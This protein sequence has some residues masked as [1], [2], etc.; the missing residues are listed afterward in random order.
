MSGPPFVS[1]LSKEGSSFS[2][3]VGFRPLKVVQGTPVLRSRLSAETDPATLAAQS[4]L[5]MSTIGARLPPRCNQFVNTGL[6]VRASRSE[7][8]RYNVRSGEGAEGLGEFRARGRSD[9]PSS[10]YTFAMAG[11]VDARNAI[12][13][14]AIGT[15][16]A[17]DHYEAEE[18]EPVPIVS[19]SGRDF[20]KLVERGSRR[21]ASSAE[22]ASVYVWSGYRTRLSALRPLVRSYRNQEYLDYT[23]GLRHARFGR[24]ARMRKEASSSVRRG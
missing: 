13:F 6:L 2:R 15:A 17:S 22:R 9:V 12:E 21:S 23:E 10:T 14:S 20:R 18:Q 19:V 8:R 3:D 24:Q 7:P 16:V 11:S 4:R 1:T 5:G